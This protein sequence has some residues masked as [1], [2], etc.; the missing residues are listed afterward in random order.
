[1]NIDKY[2]PM[3]HVSV[4]SHMGK[5]V[6]A[7]HISANK[8]NK[9]PNSTQQIRMINGHLDQ[10]ISFSPKISMGQCG[11]ASDA[12]GSRAVIGPSWPLGKTR[13]K[14]TDLYYVVR[15]KTLGLV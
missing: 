9:A 1:M 14:R 13:R 7:I 11:D 3:L 10:A 5:L 4:A 6:S 12:M 15:S 2:T 8:P